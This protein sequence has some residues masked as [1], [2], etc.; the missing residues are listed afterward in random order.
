MSFPFLIVLKGA[1]FL[2]V[3]SALSIRSFSIIY[4]L[5]KHSLLDIGGL[6]R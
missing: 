6:A 4:W 2:F 1:L 3:R 5:V